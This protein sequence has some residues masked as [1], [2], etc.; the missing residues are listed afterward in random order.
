MRAFEPADQRGVRDLVLAG[1]GEHWG[2]V[3][4]KLNPDL[5]DIA[6]SYGHGRTLVAE[7]DGALVG[8]GT[9]VPRGDG[10][11]EI[12]RVSVDSARRGRGIG[13]QIVD[14]LVRVAQ[15]WEVERVVLETTA[16]WSEVVA[17]WLRCGFVLTHHEDGRFGRDAWFEYAV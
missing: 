15:S 8:T 3:D 16:D 13:R 14:E 2:D 9:V 5:D 11:A 6:T 17:F 1:L 7:L 12:V 4:P 10:V